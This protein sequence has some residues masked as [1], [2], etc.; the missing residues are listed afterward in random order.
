[1]PCYFTPGSCSDFQNVASVSERQ[2]SGQNISAYQHSGIGLGTP[3]TDQGQRDCGQLLRLRR[4][5]G[6]GILRTGGSARAAAHDPRPAA[7]ETVIAEKIDW[8]NRLLLPKAERR[9]QSIRDTSAYLAIPGV[10][11]LSYRNF[12]KSE[13]RPNEHD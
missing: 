7:R 10:I 12:P 5:L 2:K 11:G 1:V 13:R 6:K 9:V 8:I 4:I 3:G